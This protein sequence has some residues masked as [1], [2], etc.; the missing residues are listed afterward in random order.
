MGS[1]ARDLA[2]PR[3]LAMARALLGLAGA[4]VRQAAGEDPGHDP[5]DRL[6]EL[7]IRPDGPHLHLDG[8][9]RYNA[10]DVGLAAC[11]LVHDAAAAIAAL[12]VGADPSGVLEVP[13]DRLETVLRRWALAVAQAEAQANDP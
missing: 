10:A 2:T 11:A 8:H 3:T 5:L 13:T 12:E 6:A 1:P 4:H 9:G 7:G